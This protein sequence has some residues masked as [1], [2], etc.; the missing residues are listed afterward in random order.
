MFHVLRHGRRLRGTLAG[1]TERCQVSHVGS[2]LIDVACAAFV[3][4]TA[5]RRRF[6]GRKHNGSHDELATR[7]CTGP[8]L[9]HGS[10]TKS[11]LTNERRCKFATRRFLVFRAVP[12][13]V[14]RYRGLAEHGFWN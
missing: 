9:E 1:F 3:L 6:A 5:R 11:D 8:A 4:C 7:M 13:R 10:R 12:W 14:G 2:P